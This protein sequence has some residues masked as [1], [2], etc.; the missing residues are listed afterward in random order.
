MAAAIDEHRLAAG[1]LS[2]RIALADIKKIGN[3]RRREEPSGWKN[4]T[5]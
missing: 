1:K 5:E 2:E 4:D 3:L